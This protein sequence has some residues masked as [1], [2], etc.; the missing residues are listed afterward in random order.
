VTY[1][2]RTYTSWIFFGA[3]MR[4]PAHLQV[5]ADEDALRVR[6]VADDHVE[7]GCGFLHRLRR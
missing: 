3:V 7:L 2:R 6:E 5:Q 1:S 4:L